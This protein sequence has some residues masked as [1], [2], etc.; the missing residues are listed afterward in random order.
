LAGDFVAGDGLADVFAIEDF[1]AG[2]FMSNIF[3]T[4]LCF[5]E[6][7][8]EVLAFVVFADGIPFDVVFAFALAITQTHKV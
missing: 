1:F 7:F 6:V 8:L 3:W 5:V 4:G 2:D